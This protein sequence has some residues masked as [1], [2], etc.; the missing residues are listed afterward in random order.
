MWGKMEH[1]PHAR[2]EEMFVRHG[3]HSPNQWSRI[4]R[5]RARGGNGTSSTRTNR[6]TISPTRA[7]RKL[8]FGT[9]SSGTNHQPHARGEETKTTPPCALTGCPNWCTDSGSPRSLHLNVQ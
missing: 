1:Q 2:G 4:S 8:L 7:G 6:M 9:V 5:P 3:L